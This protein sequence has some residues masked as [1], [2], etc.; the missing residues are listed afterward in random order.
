MTTVERLENW[1]QAGIISETQ[2]GTLSA[3][4]RKQ[5]FSL[6]LE[7][8]AL[9]YLGV[10]SLVGGLA[11]TFSTHFQRL[12]DVFILA[13]L[14]TMFAGCLYY[15]FS[16]AAAYSNHELESPTFVF[17]YVLYLACLLLS[18]ELG[19]IEFRF[20][21]LRD[22]W[23]NYLLF[24]SLVFFV[25]AYRFDNRF[26][27]SLALSSLA[28]WFGVKVSTFGFTSPEDL[29][30]SALAYASIITLAGTF[31]YRQGM[32]KHFLETYLHIVATVTF[33]AL[34]SGLSGS[35]D[36]IFLTALLF[37]A[38][39]SVMLGVRFRRFAFVVYGIAFGYF[40]ISGEA[41]QSIH[42]FSTTLIYLVV[43]GSGVILLVVWLSRRFGREE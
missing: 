31:M 32:K 16:K 29:R 34:L 1:K 13:V 28:G 40:G 17:D 8:N 12:G 10:L 15:C 37:A 20:E 33:V 38:A 5:R 6:F 24:A 23:D 21:W 26:V 2:Y 9:L 41:L 42:R 19:Y 4:V 36:L 35:N 27:L 11:W 25:L 7:L 30:M 3:L 43:T 18:V 14:S 39:A 22:A